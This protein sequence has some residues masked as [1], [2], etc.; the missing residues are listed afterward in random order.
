MRVIRN[1]LLVKCALH[2]CVFNIRTASDDARNY[3]GR[4]IGKTRE[5]LWFWIVVLESLWLR[6]GFVKVWASVSELRLVL[7]DLVVFRHSLMF[8]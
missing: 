7:L 1:I 3:V 2:T 4:G 8:Y 6:W 5:S